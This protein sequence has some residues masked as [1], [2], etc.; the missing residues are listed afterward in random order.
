MN[1]LNELV[2]AAVYYRASREIQDMSVEQQR[3][4]VLA[5][6]IA[7]CR[8]VAEYIDDG[9]S[10][11]K[12][13]EKRDD[14]LRMIHDLTLGR[15]KGKVKVILCVDKS[16]FDR[17][18][19]IKG[20]KYKEA[21]MDEGVCLD[22][23]IDGFLDWRKSMD[24]IV[25]CVKS[26][27]NHALSRMIGEKGL[28]GRIRVTKEGRPNQTTPYGMAK[29]ITSP[30]GETFTVQRT[31]KNATPRTWKSVFIPGVEIEQ[32]AMNYA[33]ETFANEDISYSQLAARMT[34][35][36]FPGP[37]GQGWRADTL[38]WM[39]SNPVYAGGLR[40][41]QRPRGE[42]FSVQAGKETAAQ[43]VTSSD[44]VLQWGTHEGIIDRTLWDLVQ[45]KIKR[46]FK[47]RRPPRNSGPYALSGILHC[48]NCGRPMYGC[49]NPEGVVI[50][51]CHRREVDPTQD[52]GYWIAYE[53]KLLPYLLTDFMSQVRQQIEEET[54]RTIKVQPQAKDLY[55]ALRKLETQLKTAR[56]NFLLA[57]PEVA[58][59]LME[60]LTRLERDR[61]E[62]VRKI[63][64]ETE[65]KSSRLLAWW[66]EY[67]RE[68]LAGNPVELPGAKVITVGKNDDI[69]VEGT[70]DSTALVEKHCYE[71]GGCTVVKMTMPAAVLREKLKRI[72]TMLYVWFRPKAKGKGYDMANIRVQAHISSEVCYEYSSNAAS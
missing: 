25:D 37:T 4:K 49:K 67:Q 53:P 6:A 22:S 47:T 9:K 11:S 63:G 30:S 64:A 16:R 48:G 59:G 70:D 34:Q 51:R 45:A 43:D 33:Y 42:F 56:Q 14:F 40:I 72:N 52:C 61:V 44:P 24:R 62:L 19:T 54:C 66:E 31:Q 68:F 8:I 65:S 39:L 7:K 2:V 3:E 71:D 12:N 10:G 17:L 23:P 1:E 21:L 46:N 20:A 55:K 38:T 69:H 50:Y 57:P 27:G 13:T 5:W 58:G 36:G 60:I 41:G 35:Q 28:Q 26:E 18:D 29:R 15:W 32:Q